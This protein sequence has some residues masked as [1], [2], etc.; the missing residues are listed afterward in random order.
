MT[1]LSE[2]EKKMLD[3]DDSDRHDFMSTVY[4]DGFVALPDTGKQYSREE[5]A[6]FVGAKNKPKPE[7]DTGGFFK[8]PPIEL[9]TKTEEEIA[10]FRV[11]P[12][13]IVDK[14][15]W[16]DVSILSGSGGTGKTTL[17]IYEAIRITLGRKVWG[18]RCWR[19]GRVLLISAE[20]TEENIYAK[21]REIMNAID[22][23]PLTTQ[24]RGIVLD[25][26]L[27]WDVSDAVRRLANVDEYRRVRLTPLAQEIVDASIN[28]N[29]SLVIFDPIVSFGPGEQSL[30]DGGQA[31][32]EAARVIRNGLNCCVRVISHVSKESARASFLDQYAARGGTALVDGTRSA[33]TLALWTKE[34]QSYYHLEPPEGFSLGEGEGAL[35]LHRPKLTYCA[36]NQPKILIKR[37]KWNFT[38]YELECLS[39]E[40]MREEKEAIKAEKERAKE[41][42]KAE[43]ERAKEEL[44][45]E[46]ERTK[47]KLRAQKELEKSRLFSEKAEDRE[48][49]K[50]SID[51]SYE[52]AI[53]ICVSRLGDQGVRL[54]TKKLE[55]MTSEHG[56]P[57]YKVKQYVESL[58]EQRKLF[59][60]KSDDCFYP[61]LSVVSG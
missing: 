13:C 20:D 5:L 18:L 1:K 4:S 48:R 31:V 53:L 50:K 35:V 22:D 39:V 25:S 10:G 8:R 29:I 21:I 46:K 52:Q 17:A 6:R 43:K 40:A 32:I 60:V 12:D 9:L 7:P 37:S 26:I 30:N 3:M 19:Q 47:E 24:E 34:V 44:M 54:G 55:T 57:S 27:V 41:A 16:A 49:A 2:Y 58:I 45:T 15:L 51:D 11:A 14:Y 28:D 42:I 56:V 23:P 36:A 33:A 38:H 61:Y 59:R